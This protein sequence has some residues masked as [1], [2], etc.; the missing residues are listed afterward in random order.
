MGKNPSITGETP[1]IPE[2]GKDPRTALSAVYEQLYARFGPQHWWPGDGPFEMMVGAI[3]TQSTAWTNV[4]KAILNLKNAGAL[5]PGALI[6]IDQAELAGLIHPCGYYNAKAKKLKAFLEWLGRRCCGS[7]EVMLRET[8]GRLREELLGVYGIGEETADSILLYAAG[9][10]VFVIDAYTRRII[11]RLG[12]KPSG[13]EYRCYQ[14][15]FENNLPPDPTLFNEYHA[16]FVAQ[17]KD[18]CRK[19]PLCEKCCLKAMCRFK[20]G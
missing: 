14:S 6:R 15:L 2:A 9:R 11:D 12:L 4:E 17:G 10:P 13:N 19:K 5:S 16:L 8:T 7:L 20:A 1:A 18:V 3:L